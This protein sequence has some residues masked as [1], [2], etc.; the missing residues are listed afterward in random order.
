MSKQDAPDHICR[1]AQPIGQAFVMRVPQGLDPEQA[2]RS[3]Q[4]LLDRQPITRFPIGQ[5]VHVAEEGRL[6]IRG[7]GHDTEDIMKFGREVEAV[8]VLAAGKAKRERDRERHRD[9]RIMLAVI[10]FMVTAWLAVEAV[11]EPY[12]WSAW[13]YTE[14]HVKNE[15]SVGAWESFRVID[16]NYGVKAIVSPGH[17]EV[18]CYVHYY[19]AN[20]SSQQYEPAK[21]TYQIVDLYDGLPQALVKCRRAVERRIKVASAGVYNPDTGK[22]E[23]SRRMLAFIS[24][25]DVK[26]DAEPDVEPPRDEVVQFIHDEC[27][28]VILYLGDLKAQMDGITEEHCVELETI[29]FTFLRDYFDR[30]S[31]LIFDCTVQ[32]RAERDQLLALVPIPKPAWAEAWRDTMG[33]AGVMNC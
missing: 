6:A 2:Q 24:S 10:V 1:S 23:K 14:R 17:V 15:K 12:S 29:A 18:A 21:G 33:Y 25:T 7:L 26:Q 11:A 5:Q 28:R 20:H 3:V 27:K 4:R 30:Y 13:E 16:E 22:A 31:Q 9:R 19:T 32:A 8:W